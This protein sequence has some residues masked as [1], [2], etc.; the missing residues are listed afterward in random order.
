[1]DATSNACNV[2][3]FARYISEAFTR[4][5]D[6]AKPLTRWTVRQIRIAFDIGLDAFYRFLAGRWERETS[7]D[8]VLSPEDLAARSDG[9]IYAAG[10]ALREYGDLIRKK[11]PKAVFFAENF[12]YPRAG[13][14]VNRVRSRY[15]KM[16]PL[17]AQ[18]LKPRYLRF[19]EA[20]EKK[21]GNVYSPTSR[22]S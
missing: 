11:S 10:D 20:E 13:R 15:T 17:D 21:L 16:K 7:K 19:S 2:L 12:W 9:E 3:A 4:P 14:L 1:M 22:L 18:E 6:L 5:A 8:E